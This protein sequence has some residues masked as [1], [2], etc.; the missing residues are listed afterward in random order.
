MGEGGR[1]GGGVREKRDEKKLEKIFLF[2][3]FLVR[4][5]DD[6]TRKGDSS[7]CKP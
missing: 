4:N 3:N 7:R 2:N 1:R 6:L 5:M